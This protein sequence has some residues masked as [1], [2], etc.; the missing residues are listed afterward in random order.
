[1]K[2]LIGR[3]AGEKE[4]EDMCVLF[5]YSQKRHYTVVVLRTSFFEFNVM[6]VKTN[7]HGLEN[8][9]NELEN[10]LIWAVSYFRPIRMKR[11]SSG[12]VRL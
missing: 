8:K 11:R 2:C 3:L 5:P 12:E 10:K 6:G 7:M 1:M 4:M 9:N